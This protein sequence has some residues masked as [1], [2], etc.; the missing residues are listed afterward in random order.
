MGCSGETGNPNVSWTPPK[1]PSAGVQP[2]ETAGA[3]D[4]GADSERLNPY[5]YTLPVGLRLSIRLFKT[6]DNYRIYKE[7]PKRLTPHSLSDI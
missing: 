3:L 6:S 5:K 1:D 7:C 2:W 4:W